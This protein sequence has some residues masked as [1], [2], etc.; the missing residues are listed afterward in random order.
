[1]MVLIEPSENVFKV[2]HRIGERLYILSVCI[3]WAQCTVKQPAV[4]FPAARRWR[5][6]PR[7]RKA[8][9]RIDWL[10]MNE[11]GARAGLHDLSL[12]LRQRIGQT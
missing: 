9:S 4:G 11:H 7:I 6:S 12:S 1:M 10:Y 5:N 3:S 8:R 2:M